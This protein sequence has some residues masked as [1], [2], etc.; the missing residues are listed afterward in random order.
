[1]FHLQHFAAINFMAPVYGLLF[2]AQAL[3][4]AWTGVLRGRI[5]PRLDGSLVGWAGLALIGYSVI[6]FPALALGIGRGVEGASVVGLAPD[7]TAMFTLGLLL[8]AV[9]RAPVHLAVIPVLWTLVAGATAWALGVVEDLI[10]PL[11]G[12]GSLGLILWKNRQR[13]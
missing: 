10:L 13:R 1:V 4:F 6:G 3:L 9:G 5:A 11:F 12:L 2:L 8:L 7:P